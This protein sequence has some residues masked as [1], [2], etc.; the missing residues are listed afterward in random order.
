MLPENALRLVLGCNI[1]E[2]C[3]A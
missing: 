3:V 2:P 1:L